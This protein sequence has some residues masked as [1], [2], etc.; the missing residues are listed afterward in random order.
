MIYVVGL[1]IEGI[2][3]LSRRALKLINDAT[4]LI[5]GK[6]HLA[7]FPEFKGERVVIGSNLD[8]IF[9]VLNR[10]SQIVNRKSSVVLATGD[11]NFFGIADFIIKRFGKGAVEIIPNVT[12]MQEAFARIKEGWGDARFLS[13]HGRNRSQKSEVRSQKGNTFSEI[14]D[15]IVCHDKVGIFTDPVNTPSRIARALSDRGIKDYKVYV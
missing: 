7:L 10:K 13:V 14:I 4:L 9:K 3:S 8:Y 15:E 2:S 1:G 5:G 6:R 12:T 11:P